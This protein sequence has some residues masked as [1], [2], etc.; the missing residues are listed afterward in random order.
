MPKVNGKVHPLFLHKTSAPPAAPKCFQ[1]IAKG[2]IAPF[3]FPESGVK[4]S[5]V[6][7]LQNFFAGGGWEFPII[8]KKSKGV[9]R[10]GKN[11]C[12]L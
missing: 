5:F 1:P 3:N 10:Y 9:C 4:I 8:P 12:S 6:P 11:L 7:G 2:K